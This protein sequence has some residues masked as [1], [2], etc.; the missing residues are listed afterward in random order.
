[1]VKMKIEKSATIK[2]KKGNRVIER[3]LIDY[4]SNKRIWEIRGFKPVQDEVKVEN[5]VDDKVVSLKPKKKTRKK[6]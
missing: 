3:T 6:K 2:L 5:K 1:M 4:N